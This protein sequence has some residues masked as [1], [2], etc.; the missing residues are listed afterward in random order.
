MRAAWKTQQRYRFF[1]GIVTECWPSGLTLVPFGTR[2]EKVAFDQDT[3]F[4]KGG[5]TETS[6]WR[7]VGAVPGDMGTIAAFRNDEGIWIADVIY[8]NH[9]QIRGTIS[10][11]QGHLVMGEGDVRYDKTPFMAIT[12]DM[13][14]VNQNNRPVTQAD[15]TPEAY[16][17]AWGELTGPYRLQAYR[18]ETNSGPF[19]ASNPGR[20]PPHE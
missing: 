3:R 2:T 14:T 11:V 5:L 15:F 10:A 9:H 16:L 6:T 18:V 13:N 7:D 20:T 4:W 12:W 17:I 19:L 8:F 1:K